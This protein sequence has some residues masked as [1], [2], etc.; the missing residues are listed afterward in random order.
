MPV[1]RADNLGNSTHTQR[2][3]KGE[4]EE[5][6]FEEATRK[7][8]QQRLHSYYQFIFFFNKRFRV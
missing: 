4:E 5:F 7:Y 1:K 2:E 8:T 3:I 6:V